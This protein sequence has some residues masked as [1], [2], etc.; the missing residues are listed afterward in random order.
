MAQTYKPLPSTER[1]WEL[2]SL[3]PLTGDL[4]WRVR[5][6]ARCRLDAPAG[7][8]TRN[9]YVVLRIDGGMYLA[10]RIIRAWVD[11]TDPGSHVIDHWDGNPN[12]NHPWNLRVCTQSQ[13]M[14]NVPH[15]G[16]Y[17]TASGKYAAQIRVRKQRVHLGEFVTPLEAYTAYVTAKKLLLGDFG[18]RIGELPVK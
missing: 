14:A 5:T 15:R 13:N 8:V 6:S 16:C 17:E 7:C 11:G 3:N 4:F 18:C 10:H 9:G 12:N 1:L 2:F